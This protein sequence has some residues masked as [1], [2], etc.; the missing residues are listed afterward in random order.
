M[1]NISLA[2]QEILTADLIPK[3][4]NG[5]A[6]KIPSWE[7]MEAD[8]QQAIDKL[9]KL[10]SLGEQLKTALGYGFDT[11]KLETFKDTMNNMST[12]LREVLTKDLLV[13]ENGE[14]LKFTAWEKMQKTVTDAVAKI[15]ELNNLGKQ[16]ETALGFTFNEEK[17][18]EFK[19]TLGHL[20]SAVQILSGFNFEFIGPLKKGDSS[21]NSKSN[22]KNFTRISKEAKL[23]I[24]EIT[25]LITDI[26]KLSNLQINP[27]LLNQKLLAVTDCLNQIRQF[28][29]DTKDV[30]NVEAI[31]NSITAFSNMV[32]QLATLKGEFESVG[33]SYANSLLNKFNEVN[34]TGTIMGKVNTLISDLKL[35]YGDFTEIGRTYGNNLKTGFTESLMNIAAAVS[36]A[37]NSLNSEETKIQF[38]S[39][40]RSLGNTIGNSLVDGFK[41]AIL[42]M[43]PAINEELKKIK[44][45]QGKS[46]GGEVEYYATGGLAS[47][48]K[49]RELIQY[50]QC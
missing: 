22:D 12:A 30:G 18:E 42:G 26:D 29:I 39:Q 5:K 45:A 27:E 49:N 35:K 46:N 44:P 11:G 1:A 33:T 32:E 19:K 40:V 10:N 9:E 31:Q 4:D 14:A 34:P 43:G 3:D 37:I 50:Q 24:E 25:G 21:S 8:V 15:T 48:F 2:I 41:K 36:T 23:K 6:S 28:I 17:I 7:K 16:L 13:D 38:T 47:I 20:K